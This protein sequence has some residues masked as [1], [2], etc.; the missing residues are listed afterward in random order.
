MKKLNVVKIG[1]KIID[2]KDQLDKVLAAFSKMEGP[3]I[4]IHGGGS[5]ASAMGKKLG[6]T[7]NLVEGRRITDEES[8]EVVTMVYA[9]LI[10][11]KIVAGL[12]AFG[13][14]AIGLSGADGN[15]ILSQKRPVN[16]I[17][18][19][20]VGDVKE[21]NHAFINTLLKKGLTPVFSA[22]THDG[23][24]QLLNTNADT[25]ASEIAQ[26][27]CKTHDVQLTLAFEKSG[28]LDGNDTVVKQIDEALFIKLKDENIIVDG[29][30][31]KL[32][33]AFDALNNGVS[34]VKL[35]SA[36]YLINKELEYTSV[37]L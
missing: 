29:M 23:S 10:N 30:I 19:G 28:V 17:D 18:Y 3:K 35:T 34:E 24:G 37:L 7:P 21:V 33:N 8:I 2:Q 6:L 11:K 27:M 26:A 20:F 36:D 32:T 12:Q 9:G 5:K 4:L 16:E 15:A 1:G 13:C 14:N 31:P 22:I 25:M